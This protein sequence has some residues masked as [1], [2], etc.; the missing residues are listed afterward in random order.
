MSYKNI[1][2]PT[3][4]MH[5]KNNLT[6][7]TCMFNI[8]T[9]FCLLI[10]LMPLIMGGEWS[11]FISSWSFHVHGQLME[12]THTKI[13]PKLEFLVPSRRPSVLH[14]QNTLAVSDSIHKSHRQDLTCPICQ[15]LQTLFLSYQQCVCL[16]F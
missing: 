3:V 5:K 8:D 16:G 6:Y 2:M 9:K 12:V 4:G 15:T 14:C 11:H 10:W 13:C 7:V 1:H